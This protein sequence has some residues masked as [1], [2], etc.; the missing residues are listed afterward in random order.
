MYQVSNNFHVYA[1][2]LQKNNLANVV[3]LLEEP[4]LYETYDVSSF[5]V[6]LPVGTEW[7]SWDADLRR[8]MAWH[9]RMWSSPTSRTNR[10]PLY[11][12]EWFGLVAAPICEANY[13]RRNGG[14]VTA[15]AV[16]HEIAAQDW[17]FACSEYLRR[18]IE[19]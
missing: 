11:V 10:T 9:D 7:S 13:H 4:D 1:S 2:A 8:F 15:Q 17:R 5:P 18:R 6:P 3:G 12:N 19:R 16:C 14:L